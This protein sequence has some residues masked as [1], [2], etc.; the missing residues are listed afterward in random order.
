MTQTRGAC[1][2]TPRL[3][4][5]ARIWF[6]GLSTFAAVIPLVAAQQPLV[7]MQTSRGRFVVELY[8]ERAPQTVANFLQYVDD[9]FYN[10]TL[11]HRLLK[12]LLIQ[13]G[14]YQPGMVEKRARPPI[15]NEA[16]H[17]VPNDRGTIAMARNVDAD[18][19]TS[20]FFINLADNHGLDFDG[21]ASAAGAGYCAFG[22]VVRGMNAVRAM[23]AVEVV[24]GGDFMGDVPEKEI[25]IE[26]AR[27]LPANA[28]SGGG[29][30]EATH[31]LGDDNLGP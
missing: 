30:G 27:V 8:P 11:F 22:R 23:A 19:V 1:Q 7:E 6:L 10:G 21:T 12:G 29:D 9:G 25:I 3:E 26:S 20:Q 13:G 24:S 14:G 18:S 17:C 2:G 5:K 15:A 31:E 16:R 28:R 4:L